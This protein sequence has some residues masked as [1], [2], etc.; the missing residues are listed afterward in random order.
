MQPGQGDNL[1]V[2]DSFYECMRLGLLH[3]DKVF[4]ITL[5]GNAFSVLDILIE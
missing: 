3:Q 2:K 4:R 5:F 1:T